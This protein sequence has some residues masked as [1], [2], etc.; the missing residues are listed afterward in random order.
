MTKYPMSDA[1]CNWQV[2]RKEGRGALLRSLM[3]IAL[4]PPKALEAILR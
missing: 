4:V 2:E 1:I 3:S